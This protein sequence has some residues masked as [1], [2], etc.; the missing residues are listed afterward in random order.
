MKIKID[1]ITNSSST[2][3]IVFVPNN[4][5]VTRNQAYEAY[6]A[7]DNNSYKAFSDKTFEDIE[8]TIE[9]LKMG[10]ILWSYGDDGEP[11]PP[12]YYAALEICNINSF[13]VGSSSIGGEGNNLIFGIQQEHVVE[14]LKNNIDLAGLTQTITKGVEL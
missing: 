6:E 11:D 3:Y 1:F 4:F 5:E 13:I 7:Y 8:K 9:S 10:D 2:A 12:I 14:I